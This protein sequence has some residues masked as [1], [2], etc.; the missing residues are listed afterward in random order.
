E[1]LGMIG[2]DPADGVHRDYL[3]DRVGLKNFT[4]RLDVAEERLRRLV[5]LR[6]LL[7]HQKQRAIEDLAVAFFTVVARIDI[8]TGHFKTRGPPDI[9]TQALVDAADEV[10]AMVRLLEG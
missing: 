2:N 3:Q 5:K 10:S 7:S 1:F 6:P 8:A 9:D 4:D